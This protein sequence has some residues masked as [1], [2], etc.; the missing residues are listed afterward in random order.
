M[1]NNPLAMFIQGGVVET[2][3]MMWVGLGGSVLLLFMFFL[4]FVVKQY[5]RCPSNKILVI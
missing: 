1:L 5:K 2:L 4:M 3:P